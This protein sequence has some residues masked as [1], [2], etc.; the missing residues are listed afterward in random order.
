MSEGGPSADER[1]GRRR[2]RPGLILVCGGIVTAV[3]AALSSIDAWGSGAGFED[4]YVL[5]AA[6]TTALALVTVA[7]RPKPALLRYGS[8]AC[9]IAITGAGMLVLDLAP[10]LGRSGSVL[11]SN[12]LFCVGCAWAMTLIVPALYRKLDRRALVMAALDGGIMLFAGT[13]LTLTVWQTSQGASR[14]DQMFIPLAAAA[15]LASAGAAAIAALTLRAAPRLQGVWCGIPGVSLVGLSWTLLVDLNLHGEARSTPVCLLYAAGAL[16]LGYAWM[17]WS[18]EIGGGETYGRVAR[19]LADWLPIGAIVLCVAV[20]AMPHGR[21]EGID[22][23]SVGTAIVVLLSIARQTLLIARERHASLRLTGEDLLRSEKEA[24]EAA[25]RAKSAFLAMMSHEIRTPMNAILGN[26]GLL[27]DADLKP[28]EREC[29]DAILAAGQTLLSVINDVLDFSK[30]EADRMELERV[31]F[32][33][34]MLIG[35]VVTLFDITAREKGVTLTAQID[36]SIPVMLAGDP[37]RLRQ[38]LS[39]LVGNAIK[40]TDEGGVTVRARVVTRTPA[41]TIV[42]FEVADTGVGIDDDHRARL[43]APFVQL[44]SSTTRRFGGTGLGLAVCKRLVGLMG[45]EIDVDSS[46]GAGSTFWFTANFG[47]PTDAEAGAVMA[48]IEPVDATPDLG[49]AR[50]LVAEDNIANQRLIA[51]LLERLDVVATIVA[52]GLEALAAVRTGAFDLVLMDCHMPGMDGFEATRAIRAEGLDLPIIALTANAMAG[53]REIC[54]AAGM[55]DYLSKPIVLA[56]LAATLRRWLS[57]EPA[58][59]PVA[60]TALAAA[61]L[62]AAG[63]LGADGVIDQGQMAELFELDP[64]GSAGFIGAMVESYEATVAE[65]VPMIRAAVDAAEPEALEDAAHRLKGVAANLGV[66]RVNDAAARLVALARSGTTAGG[67]TILADLDAALGPAS[68]AL[69][70]LR[71]GAGLPPETDCRAA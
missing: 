23:V 65:T 55:D 18:D 64:D 48:S 50:V 25:N 3:L 44:D 21:I 5:A 37:H 31:G 58:A 20:A 70:A 67:D 11:G 34:A 54:L 1:H 52:N 12:L 56:D 36:R 41:E 15:L 24:A 49:G 66:R 38:V 40:F 60:G 51:R 30:I 9:A 2:D 35:S 69:S 10:R 71:D 16:L 7:R 33:P 19:W 32:A 57:G 14:L 53:D 43:F 13:T 6:A 29:V 27:G 28:A 45:G 22:M 17:T 26:A 61:A 4:L 8:L 62:A 42:R 47:E 46:A 68:A 39:N 63:P 59:G